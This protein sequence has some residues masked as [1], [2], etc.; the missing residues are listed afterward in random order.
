[1]KVY[2]ATETTDLGQES[3]TNTLGVFSTK[4]KAQA[5]IRKEKKN[6]YGSGY[7]S[8]DIEKFEVDEVKA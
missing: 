5:R 8:W 4:R 6:E 3:W 7:E 2:I 1:M